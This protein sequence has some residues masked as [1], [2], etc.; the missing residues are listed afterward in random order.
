MS[1]FSD[2]LSSIEERVA[3]N[4][5]LVKYTS[6]LQ[7]ADLS[8]NAKLQLEL[9]KV[10]SLSG[11]D[12]VKLSGKYYRV[13]KYKDALEIALGKQNTSDGTAKGI[14]D[15]FLN[16]EEYL[17]V[18]PTP[19][20]ESVKDDVDITDLASLEAILVDAKKNLELIDDYILGLVTGR[21][22]TQFSLSRSENKFVKLAE[23]TTEEENKEVVRNYFNELYDHD[24]NYGNV[25]T[26]PEDYRDK[27]TTEADS[28]SKPVRFK[29]V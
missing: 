7:N 13:T 15:K 25:M 28:S 22:F 12:F 16:Y 27:L 23:D 4:S 5:N 19:I 8:N 9:E 3:P 21:D 11:N 17:N 29:K 14:N 26:K 1:K 24:P 6:D 18:A 2:A 20:S 10:S